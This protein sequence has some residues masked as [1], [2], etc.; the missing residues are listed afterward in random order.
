MLLFNLLTFSLLVWLDAD[1]RGE[2]CINFD[3]GVAWRDR[4]C[5]FRVWCCGRGVLTLSLWTYSSYWSTCCYQLSLNTSCVTCLWAPF[6]SSTFD[7]LLVLLFVRFIFSLSLTPSLLPLMLLF[8]LVDR[9]RRALLTWGAF[10]IGILF[11][12]LLL[13][14]LL[15]LSL[16]CLVSFYSLLLSLNSSL[17]LLLFVIFVLLLLS[18]LTVFGMSFL[19]FSLPFTVCLLITRQGEGFLVAYTHLTLPSVA[20]VLF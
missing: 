16:T 3:V 1:S 17:A 14:L 4:A 13:L 18:M 20:L 11:T 7:V 19:L 6:I 15:L 12:L 5:K 8:A 2:I 9:K 10:R